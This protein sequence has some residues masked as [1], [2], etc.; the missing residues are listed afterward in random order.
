MF[1]GKLPHIVQPMLF[2]LDGKVHELLI[3]VRAPDNPL[4]DAAQR[5]IDDPE[6]RDKLLVATIGCWARAWQAL[7]TGSWQVTGHSACDQYELEPNTEAPFISVQNKDYSGMTLMVHSYDNGSEA[8]R[9]A[10]APLGAADIMNAKIPGIIQLLNHPAQQVEAS[11]APNSAEHLDQQLEQHRQEA[12]D[13]GMFITQRA[14]QE[15]S[16]DTPP[17]VNA[18]VNL[19]A[20][21]VATT[22]SVADGFLSLPLLKGNP[23]LARK[24]NQATNYKEM[25]YKDGELVAFEA[26]KFER[27][28][29]SNSLRI[30]TMNG[31]LNIF[32]TKSKSDEE[33]YDFQS[34]ESYLAR[35]GINALEPFSIQQKFIYVVKVN[36]SN[37]REYLN[38][39]GFWRIPEGVQE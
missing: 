30:N 25:Q 3:I 28:Q 19:G 16:E 38:C 20:W 33:T 12:K 27:V 29:N 2:T 32:V 24:A 7:T 17:Q 8:V 21:Q 9:Q 36:H 35:I 22:E 31:V 11:L 6:L 18:G 23:G 37:D 34:A 1:G 39:Y 15:N 26:F 4:S 14:L 5:F 13:Q 10:A